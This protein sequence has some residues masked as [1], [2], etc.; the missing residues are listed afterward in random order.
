MFIYLAAFYRVMQ[1]VTKQRSIPHTEAFPPFFPPPLLVFFFFS[2]LTPSTI[3]VFRF[4]APAPAPAPVSGALVPP[5]LTLTTD[6]RPF[7]AFVFVFGFPEAETEVDL[8]LEIWASAADQSAEV[9]GMA[10]LCVRGAAV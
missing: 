1:V 3:S 10:Y 4:L 5:D 8:S 2:P 7:C 6:E 9:E